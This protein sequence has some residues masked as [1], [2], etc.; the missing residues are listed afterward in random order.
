MN[1][2]FRKLSLIAL[3]IGLIISNASGQGEV[4]NPNS[5][6]GLFWKTNGNLGTITGTNFLGT[7]DAKDFVIKTAGS[8][9]TRERMRVIGLGAAPGQ[10]VVNNTGIFAGDV[11]SAYA[12]NTTNGTTASINN[13]VG[14]FA[15]N[16]YSAANGTGIYGAVNGGASTAGTAVWGTISGTAT[17]ASTSSEGVYGSNSTAPAGTGGTAAVAS[18][19]RG[20]A[21]GA[22]GNAFTMA[23]FGV[24][25]GTAGAAYGVYGQTS[26]PSAVGVFG[27]NL[28]VSASTSH[29]IQGQTAA[30]GGA[31][32]LR[33]FNTAAAIAAG[34]AGYGARASIAVAPTGTGFAMG[35]R[36]DATGTTGSTY[37]VYGN[38]ASATGFGLDALNTNT[39]GTGII[40]VG[41]NTGGSYLGTG[42]GAAING[43]GVGTFSMATTAASGVGV[44]G[45]GNNLVGS[46]IVPASGA[47]VSGTGKQYGVMGFATTIVSTTGSSNSAFNGAAAS[48]GGY[49][50]VQSGGTAQTW[51]Y[52]AVRD[53]GGTLRKII[54]PGTVNTIV[55]DLDNKA[56]ALSC[57][58]TPENLFQDYGQGQLVKGKAH[59][60]LDP[61]FSKNIV[62]N[63]L[64]PLRVFVQLE[65]DCNGVF[66][67]NKN[68]FGFDIT[69]LH[70]GESNVPFTYTIT[71]NRADEMNPDG[72][73]AKYSA[74]RFVAAP[75]FQKTSTLKAAEALDAKVLNALPDTPLKTVP[76]L[77]PKARNPN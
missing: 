67:S 46:I 9:A 56:V 27:V 34:Q 75:G 15:I 53:N 31:S 1:F 47:G 7:T 26:S 61:I 66:V 37:G 3:V 29:A 13:A 24:N 12:N 65:A 32:A 54:G 17:T 2:T 52:V 44:V 19:V 14:T 59:I 4:L 71:A 51:A 63:E 8:A 18:A 6:N 36:G 30:V 28:D 40:A 57:P 70:A 33:G 73:V 5:T 60:N 16:G 25:S 20:D 41:N 35:V 21:S 72:S 11:F 23:V 22:A 49:F 76:A 62:V 77:K 50:E 45:I 55:K 42:S 68:Q 38:A 43:A 64:H 10:I 48:A 58:E 74:E 69:E 39:S